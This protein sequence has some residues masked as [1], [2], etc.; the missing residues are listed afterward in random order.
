MVPTIVQK[1]KSS[2]EELNLSQNYFQTIP[3]ELTH[4]ERLRS[5]NMSGNYIQNIP[6]YFF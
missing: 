4:M 2:I 5:L 3:I 6:N 1:M